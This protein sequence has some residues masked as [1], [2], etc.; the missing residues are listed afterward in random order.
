[1]RVHF[2]PSPSPSLPPPQVRGCLLHW[3]LGILMRCK[4]KMFTSLDWS[5]ITEQYN[6]VHDF[7][8]LHSCLAH[9]AEVPGQLE[10]MADGEYFMPS[11]HISTNTTILFSST[12]SSS[13]LLLSHHPLPSYPPPHLLLSFY[14][15]PPLLLGG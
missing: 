11:G 4:Y 13:P 1:M 7:L 8:S 12:F 3:H 10:E 9:Q 15:P 5:V 2:S 14:P 6:E